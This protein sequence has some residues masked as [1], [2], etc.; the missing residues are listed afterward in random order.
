MEEFPATENG[1]SRTE[2]QVLEIVVAGIQK[3]VEI[4]RATMGKEESPFMGDTTIWMHLAQLCRGTRP[5]L[6]CVDGN[7]FTL[8]E[9]EKPRESFLEQELIL[10]EDGAAVLNGRADWI[11]LSGEIER[12]LVVY[13]C[14]GMMRHGG[15]MDGSIDWLAGSENRFKQD[16]LHPVIVIC[17]KSE[18]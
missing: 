8:P 1:L 3:P 11:V 5:L 6:K 15:G 12:W 4:F 16:Q 7:A 18:G 2:E 9:R 13:I 10:T 14:K 17:C